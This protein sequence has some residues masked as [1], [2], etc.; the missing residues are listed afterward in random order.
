MSLAGIAK[1]RMTW[2]RSVLAGNDSQALDILLRL[3]A[4][5][6]PTILDCTWGRGVMWRKITLQPHIKTDRQ[7]LDGVNC[8]ADFRALPF[9]KDSVDV[10]V[11]DPPHLPAD[12]DSPRSSKI[13]SG[14]YGTGPPG[15]NV[16][17]LFDPFLQEAKRVLQP[18][19][20][21]LAKIADLVHNHRY[22][23][24]HVSFIEAARRSGMTPCD[25]LIKVNSPS[26]NL[27]SGKW[28]TQY[29]LRK[30][31]CYWIVVRNSHRCERVHK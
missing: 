27:I 28:R 22:Q 25:C 7:I 23:W 20:I 14:P 18:E 4:P 26:G 11:F 13:L 19:G 17:R 5:P 6:S 8:V 3:H 12:A 21:I 9:Q 31:H 1:D 10:I 16:S 29:H 30:A 15:D 24:Q 2:L